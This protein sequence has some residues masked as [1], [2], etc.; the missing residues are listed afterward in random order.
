MHFFLKKISRKET[1]DVHEKIIFISSLFA[2]VK[3]SAKR[4]A[5]FDSLISVIGLNSQAW[6]TAWKKAKR[7]RR[8]GR[9]RVWMPH[10]CACG[11]I[12]AQVTKRGEKG[13]KSYGLFSGGQMFKQTSNYLNSIWDLR[14]VPALESI[15]L[16]LPPL[17][18]SGSFWVPLHLSLFFFRF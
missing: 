1:R 17:S 12:H 14:G 18:L 10:L 3:V 16:L 7:E 15:A 13:A 2:R 4:F 5:S 6:R 11:C 9:A 8:N